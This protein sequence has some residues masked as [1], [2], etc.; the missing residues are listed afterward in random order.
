MG[1]RTSPSPYYPPRARWPR[2]WRDLWYRLRR[3]LHLER[4]SAITPRSSWRRV[5]LWLVIPGIWEIARGQPL[6]GRAVLQ[7]WL[8]LVAGY[9]MGMGSAWASFA[10]LATPALHSVC[11]TRV[12]LDQPGKQLSFARLLRASMTASLVVFV[13]YG[14]LALAAARRI[15][16]PISTNGTPVLIDPA[17]P[18]S[19]L[20]RGDWIAYTLPNNQLGF[21]R[22]LALP[23]ETIRF[24]ANAFEVGEIA[25]Q[26]IST[27]MPVQ[28][29]VTVPPDVL[30]VWPVG[31]RYAHG[32]EAGTAQ[33]LA[34][35]EVPLPRITGRAFNRWFWRTQDLEP[36]VSLKNW[37]PPSPES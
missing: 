15:V 1:V 14:L 35:A 31:A 28:G 23:G 16:L 2:G 9:W 6:A 21:E 29:G 24:Y 10:L 3:D 25:Y 8:L 22:V 34:L 37:S 13:L 26:R 18:R 4:L 20:R 12:L 7:V 32:G 17:T 30:F 33:L 19:T 27:A 36:L 11:A 5:A